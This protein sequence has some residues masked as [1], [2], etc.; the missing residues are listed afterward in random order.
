MFTLNIINMRHPT[1]S[2]VKPSAMGGG[3]STTWNQQ[4]SVKLICNCFLG[5]ENND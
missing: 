4:V 5:K 1:S 2:E 3:V